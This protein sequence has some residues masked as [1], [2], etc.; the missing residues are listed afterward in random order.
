MPADILEKPATV[1]D[2]GSGHPSRPGTGVEILRDDYLLVA[3]SRL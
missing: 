1:E 2:V 3:Q